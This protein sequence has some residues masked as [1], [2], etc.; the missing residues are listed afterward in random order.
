MSKPFVIGFEGYLQG[1]NSYVAENLMQPISRKFSDI[2]QTKMFSHKDEPQLDNVFLAI[3]HSFGG[4][5]VLK[6]ARKCKPKYVI[7]CDP[8]HDSPFS[9]LDFLFPIFSNFKA[10]EGVTVYNF[11]RRGLLPGYVVDGAMANMKLK[12]THWD[13]PSDPY[14]FLHAN[15]LISENF[16]ENK[17]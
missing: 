12:C 9:F 16:G 13:V 6:F 1:N 10:P 15:I 3:G 8:R 5:A 7:T 4:D 17:S 14:V 11:Y 2:V